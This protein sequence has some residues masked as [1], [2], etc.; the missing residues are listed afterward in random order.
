M[1]LNTW[2]R[3]SLA[4]ELGEGSATVFGRDSALGVPILSRCAMLGCL[5]VSD[6]YSVEPPGAKIRMFRFMRDAEPEDPMF[7]M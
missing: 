4:F 1:V 6:L 5:Q 2:R 7:L 3:V